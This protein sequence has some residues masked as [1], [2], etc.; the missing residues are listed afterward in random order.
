MKTKLLTIIVFTF[1]LNAFCQYKPMLGVGAKWYTVEGGVELY[2]NTYTIVRDTILD[3]LK[4]YEITDLGNEGGTTPILLREDSIN[5]K[6]HLKYGGDEKLL[7]DFSMNIG[8]TINA[9]IF[10]EGFSEMTL[11]SITN[12]LP[13]PDSNYITINIQIENPK[14]FHFSNGIKWIEGI[15]ALTRPI[16]SPYSMVGH[17]QLMC[18]FDS[19]GNWNFHINYT[20][21]DSFCQRPGVSLSEYNKDYNI[22]IYPNPIEDYLH[23]NFEINNNEN[24]RIE[25]FDCVGNRL[26][27]DETNSS[28]QHE[29][30]IQKL[31]TGFYFLQFY[32]EGKLIG[33][34]K[35]I[36][37]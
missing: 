23:I 24:L 7:Y 14:I 2:H 35:L 9:F 21:D 33:T 8:D 34:E 25:L 12:N 10:N 4:Y 27:V 3:G 20:Q 17:H 22:S 19:I 18:Q 36:K 37:Q 16:G 29:V 1:S 13:S 31:N 6:I 5:R 15:G 28:Q 11:D 26:M 32:S 30:D